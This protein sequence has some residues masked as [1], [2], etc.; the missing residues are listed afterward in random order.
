M[1]EFILKKEFI[2]LVQFLKVEGFISSGGEAR[3]FME[4]ND[5]LLNDVV[6]TEKKKK[7]VSGSILKINENKYTFTHDS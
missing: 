6:V 3:H 5:I 7:I 1:K 4:E 2:T